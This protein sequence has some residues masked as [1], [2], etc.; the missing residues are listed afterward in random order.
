MSRRAFVARPRLLR[1]LV[2]GALFGLLWWGLEGG[3]AASLAV[4][5]A[6]HIGIALALRQRR[7]LPLRLLCG[8]GLA[9]ALAHALLTAHPLGAAG[10]LTLTLALMI[11][12]LLVGGWRSGALWL[13][14]C[15]GVAGALL[16]PRGPAEAPAALG[17]TDTPI[18]VF[19]VDGADWQVLDPLLSA[20]E[21]PH[22]AALRE[23]G[24]HGVLRAAP[25]LA[26]PVLWTTLL[27]GTTPGRHGLQSWVTADARNR[28][29]PTLWEHLAAQGRSSLT[30]NVPGTW[31]P[32]EAPRGRLISGFPLPTLTAGDARHLLGAVI[33][34]ATDR[35][36]EERQ[37]ALPM[38]SPPERPIRHALLHTL[39]RW[40]PLP[41]RPLELA[42][43]LRSTEQ[44]LSVRGEGVDALTLR[45]GEWS[46]WLPVR[47]GATHG[48]LRLHHL[49]DRGGAAGGLYV[50]PLL[51]SPTRPRHPFTAGLEAR[52]LFD[53]RRPYLPETVAWTAARD[54]RRAPLVTELTLEAEEIR[55]ETAAALLTAEPAEV[56]TFVHT[57]TDRLQH[58]FWPE[59]PEA[60]TRA[61]RL[62]DQTLGRLTRQM[63]PD[64]L[65]FVVS[66]HGVAASEA[67]HRD[68]GV[69]IAAGPGIDPSAAP[70]ELAAVDL[71]PT[72]LGCAGVST[73][74]GFDGA[75]I[76][77]LCSRQATWVA[78]GPPTSPRRPV[79]IDPSR[80][81]QLEALGYLDE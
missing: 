28:A 6:A 16:L 23:R 32:R 45:E 13:T 41:G 48:V 24:A 47:L 26:S 4:L 78:P 18:L 2:P 55:A 20:G 40:L 5:L 9:P 71:T 8:L 69:W 81:S 49:V 37:V 58:A 43:T 22:L 33:D 66:D 80:R 53:D 7:L 79:E 64:T 19:G 36:E 75:P 42:L 72:I 1:T 44:G 31:P 59:D 54:P 70:R 68:A 65:V 30:V 77:G 11:G 39:E 29:V 10:D 62:A 74:T 61:Y 57:A 52:A 76:E 21:L 38:A 12:G 3:S 60:V 46:P 50:T 25:P 27:T 63:P 73:L 17:H 56:V 14:L 51:Q 15:G 67:G 35:Q 34:P